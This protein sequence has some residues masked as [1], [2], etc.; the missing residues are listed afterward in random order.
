LF[1]EQKDAG[2]ITIT[3]EEMTRFWITLEGGIRFVIKCIEVMKGGEIFIP[4][5]PSMKVADLA[6]IIA[7]KARKKIIGIRP[8]EKLHE[9]LLTEEE[10]RHTK[11]FEDYFII[12][13]E[14]SF[15]NRD[16]FN[17][18]KLL[19]DR[20]QYTSGTNTQWITREEMDNMLKNLEIEK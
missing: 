2:E 19:T 5:I 4:K 14:F 15:W 17:N 20:F 9:I 6:E 1:K 18:G 12:E 10:S 11:E 16:N 13:P 8:G 3:D 7:P